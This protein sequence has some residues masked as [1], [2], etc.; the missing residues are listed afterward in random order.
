MASRQRRV[1]VETLAMTITDAV[2]RELVP[3]ITQRVSE[4]SLAAVA[5][6]AGQV[7]ELA[8]QIA[9]ARAQVA[10][11]LQASALEERLRGLGDVCERFCDEAIALA[12]ERVQP[13]EYVGT[14]DDAR[15]YTRNEFVTHKGC[16]WHARQAVPAG[17][18]PGTDRAAE[19]W[20]LAVK[21][22]RDAK[23][24]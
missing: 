18:V 11:A 22:G 2:M 8:E 1:E 7:A 19:C 6:L 12:L 10:G 23:G 17:M 15:E 9:Q 4:A 3:A 20:T 21:S 16:L 5:P 24:A 14:F 13:F